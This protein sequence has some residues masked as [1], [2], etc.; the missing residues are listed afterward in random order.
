MS[1]PVVVGYDGSDAGS[2]AL[3][4]AISEAKTRGALLVVVS[5]TPLPLVADGGAAA[6]GGLGEGLVTTL[7]MDEPP[8]AER[9]LEAARARI[10]AAEVDADYVWDVGEPVTAILREAD[11]R[12]AAAV[13]KGHHT[14]VARWLGQDVAAE[15]ERSAS[16]PVIVVEP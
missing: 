13:G 14:R 8:E 6:Y 9:L 7:P 4:R 15:L 5:A 11:N 10:D 3:D 16:C 2:A 1:S 12:N